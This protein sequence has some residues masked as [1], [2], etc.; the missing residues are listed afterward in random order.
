MTRLGNGSLDEAIERLRD[1][2]EK[3]KDPKAVYQE[4]MLDC[5]D[6]EE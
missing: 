6:D 3:N 2:Q 1:E 5:Q 4:K